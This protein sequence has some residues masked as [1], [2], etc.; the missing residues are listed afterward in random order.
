V[1]VRALV[2]SAL[3]N[4]DSYR[5]LCERIRENLAWRYFC[6]LTLTDPV[7]DHSTIKV[8]IE[9]VGSSAFQALLER[10]NDELKHLELLSPRMYMDF[11]MVQA[12]VHTRCLASTNL[13]PQEFTQRATEEQ[14]IFTICDKE[15][16]L[17]AEGKSASLEFQH[18]Q[19]ALGR[20]P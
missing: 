6:H 14:G 17:P 5:Q 4:L 9:R 3:Y 8:L 12:N 19:D 1:L 15:P 13:L 16:A 18:Y 20:L 7:F 11:A 10:L 2:L